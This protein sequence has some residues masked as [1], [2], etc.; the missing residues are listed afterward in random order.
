MI[1]TTVIHRRAVTNKIPVAALDANAAPFTDIDIDWLLAEIKK[2][3]DDAYYTNK[4]MYD[5][6]HWLDGDGWTGPRPDV[7]AQSEYGVVMAQIE[8]AFVSKNC[9]KEVVNRHA[10]GVIGREPSWF[11]T[12]K[13]ADTPALRDPNH[14]SNRKTIGVVAVA[15]AGETSPT[16]DAVSGGNDGANA[17]G[18]ASDKPAGSGANPNGKPATPSGSIG[19]GPV[20]PDQL[21]STQDAAP[22]DAGG[23]L[24]AEAEG[25]LTEWWDK[26]KI[27]KVF[28]KFVVTALM[29]GRA[30]LRVYVPPGL[31]DPSGSLNT[32]GDLAKALD[33]IY[34]HDPNVDEATIVTNENTMQEMGIYVHTNEDGAEHAEVVYVV[35]ETTPPSSSG[36]TPN[37]GSAGNG[38][39]DNGSL[40]TGLSGESKFTIIQEIITGTK[41][42]LSGAS[43]SVTN[44]DGSIDGNV[45]TDQVRLPL[46][47]RLTIFELEIPV[48]VTEQVRKLNFAINKTLTMEDENINL[49]GYLER[50]ILNG[51]LP[52]HYE[53]DPNRK[54]KQIFVRD[55]YQTG[56]G[57]INSI[58]G[59]PMLGA[60]GEFMGLA[61]PSIDFR[62]P[63]GPETFDDSKMSFYRTLLEEVDQVHYLLSGDQYAS[64]ESRK[65]ARADFEASLRASRSA[66]NE[67]LRWSL[68]TP[69]ALGSWIAGEPDKFTELRAVGDVRVDPGPATTDGIRAAIELNAA[70]GLSQQS[71]MMW[72]GV[73]DTDAEK[74]LIAQE[75][76]EGIIPVVQQQAN[77]LAAG[78]IAGNL[79]PKNSNLANGV[80]ASVKKPPRGAKA[81]TSGKPIGG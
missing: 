37:N 1:P 60:K 28:R 29:S 40:D 65:Q 7:D 5:G 80:G 48:L 47:G 8:R 41:E 54:G 15:N 9:I 38:R 21:L 67:A 26:R 79:S 27:H 13:T 23:Q 39:T 58:V 11:L 2:R 66:I 19:V 77:A 31:L 45:F 4:R 71:M 16:N 36:G 73:D 69:L 56:G 78:T 63:V 3:T 10:N 46:G 35:T 72:S 64:G 70:G 76:S 43:A 68:E 44:G 12:M 74:R 50:T 34:L 33:R 22:L 24:I 81:S 51:Q 49:A 6:D 59:T 75:K 14:P 32:N 30:T 55:K 62:E 20:L 18:S 57:A 61:N 17:S 53:D 25:P 42:D 52:G